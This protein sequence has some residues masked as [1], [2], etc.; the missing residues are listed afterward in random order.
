MVCHQGPTAIPP[1]HHPKSIESHE[2]RTKNHQRPGIRV[3][4]PAQGAALR[5][6][7]PSPAATP[8]AH[9]PAR[10]FVRGLSRRAAHALPALAR[11]LL[12]DDRGHPAP[13]GQGQLHLRQRSRG[14][15]GSHPDARHRPRSLLARTG[16]YHRARCLAR[17]HLP[18]TDGAHQPRNERTA[19]TGHPDI[20]G[21]R[22]AA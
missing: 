7:A 21:R 4:Q 14:C 3:H 22:P 13:D 11:R 9:P 20:Q 17:R 16:G 2:L 15:Q 6:R 5:P 19:H 10:P 18:A 1:S 12:P 8:D